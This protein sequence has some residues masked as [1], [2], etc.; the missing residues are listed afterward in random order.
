[1]LQ[2]HQREHIVNKKLA[3]KGHALSGDTIAVVGNEFCE[4]L[5]LFCIDEF[6]VLDIADAMILMR[7]FDSFKDNHLKV[8][9]TSNRPPE[10]LYYDGL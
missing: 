10:D 5:N 7:L 6:Q 1:M 4:N 2:I 3:G 9:I 8:V